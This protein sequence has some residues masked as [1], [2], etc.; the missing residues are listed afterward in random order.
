MVVESPTSVFLAN[1]QITNEFA[2]GRSIS[3][4]GV[5]GGRNLHA[6]VVVVESTTSVFLTNIE[7]VNEFSAEGSFPNR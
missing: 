4:W 7:I 3:R 2:A 6:M 1:F 5:S